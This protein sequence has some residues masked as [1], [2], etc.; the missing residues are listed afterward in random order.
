[1]SNPFKFNVAE[2]L[3]GTGADGMPQF[4]TQSG[5]T[6]QRIGVEMIAVP[7]GGEVTVE[8]T[9]TPLGGAIM[10][11]AEV[12][13]TLD[14][15]CVRCLRELHPPLNL[16]ITQVYANDPDFI[17]GDPADAGDEGSGDEIPLIDNDELDIVQ[18]VIDEAG[19]S[20]PFNPVCED[21]CD[22]DTPEG[23]STGVS[24]EDAPVDSRWSGLEKFL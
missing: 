15:E 3:H 8:A 23:V 7:A 12:T 17:D 13:G 24:G 14:G 20:L 22:I 21:G 9:L 19:L 2:L 16:H 1:M 10:V 18:A 5:P 6:P 4:R 11:D